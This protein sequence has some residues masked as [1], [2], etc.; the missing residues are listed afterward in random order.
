MDRIF[1]MSDQR[2]KDFQI[3]VNIRL[4]YNVKKCWKAKWL[5]KVYHILYWC[6]QWTHTYMYATP[7]FFA[8]D[9]IRVCRRKGKTC[10]SKNSRQARAKTYEFSERCFQLLLCYRCYLLLN[11]LRFY[12]FIMCC[13][14]LQKGKEEDMSCQSLIHN[15][16]RAVVARCCRLHPCNW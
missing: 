13:V 11:Y 14:L 16:H 15:T 12:S 8:A 4:P 2:W 3:H 5:C 7:S 10:D 9:N 1:Q 6:L